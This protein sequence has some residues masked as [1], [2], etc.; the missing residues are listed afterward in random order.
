MQLSPAVTDSIR[1]FVRLTAL[2]VNPQYTK[3]IRDEFDLLEAVDVVGDYI[4]ETAR[5][6]GL[7]IYRGQEFDVIEDVKRATEEHFLTGREFKDTALMRGRNLTM[8]HL[9][10]VPMI[11]MFKGMKHEDILENVD[12]A[13]EKVRKLICSMDLVTH[14][15]DALVT[16]A[17]VSTMI[18][19]RENARKLEL[20]KRRR[21][22][23]K[24]K[25]DALFDWVDKKVK[26]NHL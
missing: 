25:K 21:G 19:E 26:E 22:K 18:K 20:A 16:L 5:M 12:D 8:Y 13:L 10:V 15:D 6:V 3:R 23:H 4:H 7:K 2:S 14:Y 11:E 9:A 24:K 17:Q 1:K